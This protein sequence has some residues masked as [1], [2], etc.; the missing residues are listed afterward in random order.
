MPFSNRISTRMNIRI[1]PLRNNNGNNNVYI[2]FYALAFVEI[3]LANSM[4]MKNW[5]RRS[6]A[7]ANIGRAALFEWKS[8]C[9]RR[10]K[11]KKRKSVIGISPATHIS[12]NNWSS[13][14][15]FR[16]HVIQCKP[17][18]RRK[19]R[20]KM[21]T[22]PV[23]LTPQNIGTR[24]PYPNFE[25]NCSWQTPH[26]PYGFTQPR[27]YKLNGIFWW[28]WSRMQRE[29]MPFCH[30]LIV[31]YRASRCVYENRTNFN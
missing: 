28:C 5:F 4:P 13:C 22:V 15:I 10:R 31:A 6:S 16:E 3:R 12:I 14:F 24:T 26:T 25:L 27:T 17:K 20:G 9:R 23:H 11:K 1:R 19:N 8:K 2:Y 30:E 21:D 7:V 18:W 29:P